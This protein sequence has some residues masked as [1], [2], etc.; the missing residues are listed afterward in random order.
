MT[1]KSRLAISCL[2]G[3]AIATLGLLLKWSL[4]ESALF[5][6]MPVMVFVAIGTYLLP[7][8]ITLPYDPVGHPALWFVGLAATMGLIL[9]LAW[10]VC[11]FVQRRFFR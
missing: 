4:P 2:V 10:S 7:T 11:V 3:T 6:A 5:L 1:W 9:Y 8:A